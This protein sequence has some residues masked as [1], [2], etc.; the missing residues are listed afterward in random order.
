MSYRGERNVHKEETRGDAF[1]FFYREA[2]LFLPV[3]IS[4]LYYPIGFQASR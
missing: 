2:T 3:G 1:F 4:V